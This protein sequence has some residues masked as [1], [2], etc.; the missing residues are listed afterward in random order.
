MNSE[1][2]V[3]QSERKRR[4]FSGKIKQD[5]GLRIDYAGE[6]EQAKRQSA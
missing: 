3:T 2:L 4:G 5:E 1:K 6:S